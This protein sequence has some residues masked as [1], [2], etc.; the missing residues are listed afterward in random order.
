MVFH[1][2]VM[3]SQRLQSRSWQSG[4]FRRFSLVQI[5]LE[6]SKIR[7]VSQTLGRQSL[8]MTGAVAACFDDYG[9]GLFS[10]THGQ[11]HIQN[12]ELNLCYTLKK[13]LL[14]VRLLRHSM[15]AA[16]VASTGRSMILGRWL[17]VACF[18][19][20]KNHNVSGPH[21]FSSVITHAKKSRCLPRTVL[22]RAKKITLQ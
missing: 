2:D 12:L 4:A 13:S 17:L 21:L 19:S 20:V 6:A 8:Y 3:V 7:G 18:S 10:Q 11:H 5:V 22:H 9:D 14:C 15:R 1:W 16:D